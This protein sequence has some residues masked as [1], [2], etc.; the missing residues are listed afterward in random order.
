MAGPQKR[1]ERE[2][3]LLLR[4]KTN[5]FGITQ[6]SQQTGASRENYGKF[7]EK[8][9]ETEPDKVSKTTQPEADPTTPDPNAN[10]QIEIRWIQ[11][12]FESKELDAWERVR[13]ENN[14]PWMCSIEKP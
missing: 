7:H 1:T 5:M 14:M 9:N 3:N 12:K 8:S 6:F 4:I 11:L 13:K 2:N 10:L